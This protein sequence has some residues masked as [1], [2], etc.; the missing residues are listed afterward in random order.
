[1]R[2]V[3]QAKSSGLERMSVENEY[4]SGWPD[5]RIEHWVPE[6]QPQ[7]VHQLTDA[8]FS[9]YE[10]E[11]GCVRLAGCRLDEH[12]VFAL[13][14]GEMNALEFFD[15]HGQPLST[16]IVE[17]LNLR[18]ARTRVSPPSSIR[19]SSVER[20][21]K[22]ALTGSADHYLRSLK[23]PSLHVVWCLQA[24]GK[25][26]VETGG[27]SAT[28]PFQGWALLISQGGWRPPMFQ[29]SRSG[30]ESYQVT[31]TDSGHLTVPEAVVTCSASGKRCLAT[32]LEK[33]ASSG[34]LVL[35]EFLQRCP[36]T[37][38]R[39]QTKEL[40]A[41][42]QCDQSVVRQSLS[43][44][45]CSI[46]QGVASVE[47]ESTDW[48]LAIQKA[49]A[50]VHYGHWHT[51]TGEEYVVFR[52]TAWRGRILIVFDRQTR[53][54]LAIRKKSWWNTDWSSQVSGVPQG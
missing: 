26:T 36:A 38:A 30:L 46:C 17:T 25:L 15:A 18:T 6:G 35:P 53:S 11:D 43:N 40:V 16:E 20:W 39:V 14:D 9:P 49:C 13:Q 4:L 1:M 19:P 37:G 7:H 5:L 3:R 48:N 27:E 29:C 51:G 23:T 2:R 41:C 10:V 12:P 52:G 28:F 21:I 22:N 47:I 31:K 34:A 42:R 45:L 24:Q 32:E 50:G 54:V 8:L 44:G 33:C